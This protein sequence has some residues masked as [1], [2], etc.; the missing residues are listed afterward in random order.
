M[1]E[2]F[3]LPDGV[4]TG[5]FD[6]YDNAQPFYF[7]AA[8]LNRALHAP[9]ELAAWLESDWMAFYCSG[10]KDRDTRRMVVRLGQK[11]AYRIP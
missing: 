10:S 5:G 9:G 4:R 1:L 2:R 3:W 6:A 8:V 11:A 7:R